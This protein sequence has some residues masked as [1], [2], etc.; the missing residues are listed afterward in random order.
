MG[1]SVRVPAISSPGVLAPVP[2]VPP[3]INLPDGPLLVPPANTAEPYAW[4]LLPE[5]HLYGAYLA[6]DRESRL[7]LHWVYERTLG[8]VWDPT[9]GGRVGLLRYGTES[10]LWPEG[11]QLDVEAAAFPRVMSEGPRD[12]VSTDF[13]YGFPLTW[14]RG[15]WESKFGYYHLSSHLGDEMMVARGTFDRLNYVRDSLVWGLSVRPAANVRL[16]AE[17][18][19]AFVI[20]G[21]AKPWQFQFGLE[22]SPIEPAGWRASPFLAVNCRLREDVDFSGNLVVQA[23]LRWRSQAGRLARIGLHYFNGLSDHAQFYRQFEEQIGFGVW[24]DY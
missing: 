11:F 16:Y 19:W 12:L 8:W 4:Q 10:A 17:A 15:A 1:G 24:Y 20:D 21:G 9:I 2:R 14:R 6:G 7:A 23:G 22:L 13:R 3:G 5:G 18:D